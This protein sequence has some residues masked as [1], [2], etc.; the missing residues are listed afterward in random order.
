M[1]QV[2]SAAAESLR[3]VRDE[4]GFP[5]TYG[6]RVFGADGPQGPGLGI[7]FA[8]G[9]GEGDQVSDADGTPVFVAPEVADGLSEMALDVESDATGNG[10]GLPQLVLRPA[11]THS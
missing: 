10:T 11:S 5:E 8:E 1:L 4:Q 3:Q 7:G 6:V 9:P 2:S